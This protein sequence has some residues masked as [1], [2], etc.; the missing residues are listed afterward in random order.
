[1]S[2]MPTAILT[3][4]C[5]CSRVKSDGEW[6]NRLYWGDQH[7]SHGCCP[8]CEAQLMSDLDLAEAPRSDVLAVRSRHSRRPIR[9]IVAEAA[10]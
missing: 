7:Y 5:Y 6:Q 2:A 8:V 4:C 10:V 1:M 9:A 3:K